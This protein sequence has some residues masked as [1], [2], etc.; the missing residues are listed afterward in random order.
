MTAPEK[1]REFFLT[2]ATHFAGFREKQLKK[3]Y[4]AVEKYEDEIQDALWSDLKKSPAETYITET[5]FI[6]S[7]IRLAIRQLKKWMRPEKVSTNLVNQPS[8]SKIINQPK[9]VVLIIGP[10]NYPIQLCLAP[11]VGAIAAGNCVIIKP[12]ELAPASSILIKKIITEFF[13]SEYIQVVEGDGGRVVSDLMEN[14]RFDHIFY[15]GSTTVGRTI[16][17]KAAEQLIPVTLEL[18]GKSPVIVAADANIKVAARR[19]CLSKFSNAGQMC[20]A[21]DHILVH[22]SVED[23]LIR[24]LTKTIHD[25]FGEI[26]AESPDYGRIINE[27]RFET[28]R[29]YLKDGTLVTGGYTDKRDLYIAPTILKDVDLESDVMKE[30]IF[31]PILPVIRYS[32][33]EELNRILDKNSD[34]LALYIFTSDQSKAKSIIGRHP[35]GG[36]CINNTA[37]HFLNSRLPFGGIRN[38]GLGRYHGRFGFETFSHQRAVMQTPTWFDPAIKYPPYSGKM[39]IIKRLLG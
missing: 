39:G 33:V 7:E 20:I 24:A 15:T 4:S 14:F 1:M 22:K 30:E 37:V 3:L 35:S 27:K 25:F 32:S 36:V 9:G 13:S 16:N 38:S 10:W 23:E 6:K 11:L 12:S 18:G 17:I 26:P 21:P 29:G 8:S 5:G 31:G 34:P 2:G 19:I 28:L